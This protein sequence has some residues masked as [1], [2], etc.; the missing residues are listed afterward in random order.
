MMFFVHVVKMVFIFP[1]NIVLT[2]SQK[3]KC[4]ILPKKY[5]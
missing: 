1:K 3:S 5:T 4:D 2:L